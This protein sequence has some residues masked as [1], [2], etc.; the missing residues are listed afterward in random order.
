MHRVG[1]RLVSGSLPATSAGGKQSRAASCHRAVFVV[2]LVLVTV[3]TLLTASAAQA[4]SV[5]P[6]PIG[7]QSPLP[8]TTS[9]PSPASVDAPPSP[10]PGAVVFAENCS[11]CHGAVGGG[12]FGPPL[13]TAGSSSL[14]VTM[15]ERGGID[16]P[17]FAD[18]L[19]PDEIRAVADHVSQKLAAPVTRTA[20]AAEGGEIFRLYCSG[21]HG[22]TGAGGA[23]TMGGNAPP[24]RDYPPA[25][26]LAAMYYGR[27]NMPAF[28]KGTLDLRQQ[29]AVALYVEVLA[30]PPSPGGFGLGY[31]GPVSEGM[32]AGGALA[33]LIL[34]AVWLAWKHRRAVV[35]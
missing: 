11:G 16:M 26:A 29:T 10:D 1:V 30:D 2:C 8:A 27:R 24:L 33:V 32:V 5:S 31:V 28:V 35:G 12:G 21:C 7:S 13:L 4:E 20:Q 22:A 25:E 17:S 18:A 15:V 23:L 3:A 14:V 6:E 34:L 19:D 9:S